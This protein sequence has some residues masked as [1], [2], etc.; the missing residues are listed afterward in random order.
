MLHGEH[1]AAGLQEVAEVQ[2]HGGWRP[3][4]VPEIFGEK[5]VVEDAVADRQE[6]GPLRRAETCRRGRGG[7]S[8]PSAAV[9]AVV[10]SAVSPES[11]RPSP[12]G[13]SPAAEKESEEVS[14]RVFALSRCY[15][16]RLRNAF[17]PPLRHTSVG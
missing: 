11:P 15:F 7:V 6:G 1:G 13:A 12:T 9:L 2:G 10:T 3:E 14:S 8:E 17:S 16:V 5:F 4:G